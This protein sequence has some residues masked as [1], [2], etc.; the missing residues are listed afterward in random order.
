CLQTEDNV[1]SQLSMMAVLVS[2]PNSKPQFLL[3]VCTKHTL[4]KQV[5]AVTLNLSH[6]FVLELWDPKMDKKE[7]TYKAPSTSRRTC[8]THRV[9]QAAM[10]SAPYGSPQCP[11]LII[12][13]RW[14]VT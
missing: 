4:E 12:A 7:R 1:I 14:S 11:S 13:T 6:P 9:N 8:G 2:A 5:N 10:T 3:I